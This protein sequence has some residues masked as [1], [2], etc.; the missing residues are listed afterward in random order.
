MASTEV[1][2]P[3]EWTK[4]KDLGASDLRRVTPKGHQ[5]DV[6]LLLV[7]LMNRRD[8]H[9][10]CPEGT[11]WYNQYIYNNIYIIYSTYTVHNTKFTSL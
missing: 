11:A 8:T 9:W 2:R 4:R 3:H 1:M 6:L 10:N 7:R 5:L